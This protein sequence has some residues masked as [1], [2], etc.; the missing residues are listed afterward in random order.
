MTEIIIDKGIKKE[1]EE[2]NCPRTDL[3]NNLS[4]SGEP[5]ETPEELRARGEGYNNP[6][7][8]QKL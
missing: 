6:S 2:A 1:V 4:F 5:Q 7:I 8:C 3:H